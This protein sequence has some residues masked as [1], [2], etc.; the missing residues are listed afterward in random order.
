MADSS[1]FFKSMLAQFPMESFWDIPLYQWE[2][3]WYRSYHLQATMALRSH[4]SSRDDDIIL[5]SSMKTG[6]TWL[7]ALCFSIVNSAVDA[8]NETL[9]KTNEDDHHHHPDPLVENHPAVYV[10]TLEVQ[11]FTANPPPD[12]SSMKSP[13]LFHAHLP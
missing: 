3:F 12:V 9:S 4:F 11:V 6:T 13:R 8:D 5:A 10:Q 7:K 1:E 2:G